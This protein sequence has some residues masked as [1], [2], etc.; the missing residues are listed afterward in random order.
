MTIVHEIKK[1]SKKTNIK[2]LFLAGCGAIAFII[3]FIEAPIIIERMKSGLLLC[4]KVII[5]SLFPYMVL[6][7]LLLFSK[8]DILFDK[9]AGGLFQKAFHL[10]RCAVSAFF[11]GLL[12]GFPVGT[13][14]AYSLYKKDKITHEELVHILLF[15]NIQSSAFIINTVGISLL[16]SKKAGLLLYISQILSLIITGLISNKF[17]AGRNAI[18]IANHTNTE[19]KKQGLG[20]SFTS[21]V[22]SSVL[23]ILSICGFVLFFYVLCGIITNF[24]HKLAAPSIISVTLCSMLEMSCG[25]VEAAKSL[26]TSAA[27]LACSMILGFSGISIHFQIMS[28]CPDVEIKY[29]RFFIFKSFTSIIAGILAVILN[30]IFKIFV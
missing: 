18:K 2:S 28:L 9:Y 21:S 20:I 30:L 10:P 24:C 14:I 7:E 15:C 6:S 11:L 16:G 23:G 5:P 13:K 26:S 8:I 17:S 22:K 3:F 27:F 1:T 4:A 12:C 29:G 19:Q 25:C